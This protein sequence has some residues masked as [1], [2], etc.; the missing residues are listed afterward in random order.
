[1]F[2]ATAGSIK[3]AEKALLFSRIKE[4]TWLDHS[5][6]NFCKTNKEREQV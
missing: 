6:L 2:P 1:M 3:N 5:G 4:N